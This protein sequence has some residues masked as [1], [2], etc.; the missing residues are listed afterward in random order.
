MDDLF[1]LCNAVV[2][3]SLSSLPLPP[4]AVPQSLVWPAVSDTSKSRLP[5]LPGAVSSSLLAQQLCPCRLGRVT[6]APLLSLL[7][8]GVPFHPGTV[9]EIDPRAERSLSV[10]RSVEL[11]QHSNGIIIVAQQ[12]TPVGHNPTVEYDIDFGTIAIVDAVVIIMRV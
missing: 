7:V 11:S 5:K 8:E 4:A 10:V 9:I 3:L 1:G 6:V 2:S 12:K